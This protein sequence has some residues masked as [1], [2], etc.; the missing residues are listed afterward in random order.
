MDNRLQKIGKNIRRIRKERLL[1]QIDFAVTVGIDR[2]Y[3]SEIE[4][5]K[6]NTSINI[7]L[8]IA[9]ALDVSIVKLLDV[10]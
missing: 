1:C 9:D 3:L 5:G 10:E 2:A 7:L 4:N 6:T 8:A